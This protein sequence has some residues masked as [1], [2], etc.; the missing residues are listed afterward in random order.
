M[1]HSFS[2]E[3]LASMEITAMFIIKTSMCQVH[4]LLLQLHKEMFMHIKFVHERSNSLGIDCETGEAYMNIEPNQFYRR[5]IDP[6]ILFE[7]NA[8]K[9]L[10]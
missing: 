6:V 8:L 2:I 10:P 1:S 9:K 3:S 5:T 7:R 4:N